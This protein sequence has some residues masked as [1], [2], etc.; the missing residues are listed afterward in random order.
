M[1]SQKKENIS[2]TLKIKP[3]IEYIQNYH[4]KW[5]EQMNRM[6]KGRIPKQ[7]LCY[8]PRGRRSIRHPMKRREENMRL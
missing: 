6:N 3:M 2:D 4:R 1:G 7:I 8:Q 5:E